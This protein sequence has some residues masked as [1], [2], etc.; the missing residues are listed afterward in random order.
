MSDKMDDKIKDR[1][2][3]DLE[4][5][6]LCKKGDID[7]FEALV[8]RHQKRMLN[9]AYRMTD[10]YEDACDVVQEA[11]L[12]AFKSIKS[13]RGEA[14]FS[15]WLTGILINHAKNR[16]KQMQRQSHH[17][18]ASIDDVVETDSGSYN[19]EPQSTE[20][21]IVEQLMQKEVQVQVQKC[22]SLLDETSREVVI[23]RDMQGFSYEE[24][25]NILKLPDGTIKSRLF[26]A[27][28]ALRI[29]LKKV[30]GDL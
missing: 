1:V 11:F 22:I 4:I 24:I 19:S 5:V 15:T 10:N 30:L 6:L 23:L 16:L 2:D 17:E 28:D 3:E 21:P 27:R 14:R 8:E 18:G 25:G 13:F 26:R 20:I 9:I 7:A 29:C 12:S